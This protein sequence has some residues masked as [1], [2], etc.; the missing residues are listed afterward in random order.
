MARYQI[1]VSYDGTNFHGSQRQG[2]RRTIQGELEKALTRIGWTGE[3][4]LLAGRT[5]TG[6]HASG[7]VAAFDH[8][9]DHDPGKLLKAINSNLPDDLAVRWIDKVPALF[10]PR[11]DALSRNGRQA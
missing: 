9:W 2:Q 8:P 11:F 3:S 1:I 4:I 7:Q 10:H 5:D 6:V